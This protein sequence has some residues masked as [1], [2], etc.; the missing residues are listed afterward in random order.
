MKEENNMSASA[1]LV[2][3][4]GNVVRKP[5]LNYTANGMAVTNLTIAVNKSYKKDGKKIQSTDFIPVVIYG[6]LAENC[7]KYLDKGSGVYVQGRI[8]IRSWENEEGKKRYKTDIVANGI[9]FLGKAKKS[10]DADEKKKQD[11]KETEQE[12]EEIEDDDDEDI[13]F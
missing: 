7:E 10:D 13:P 12:A 2:I 4:M 6:T 3:L 8:S 1:N 5:E 11:V 9:Q